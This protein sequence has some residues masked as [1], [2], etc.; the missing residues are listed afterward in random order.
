MVAAEDMK[1]SPRMLNGNS[2]EI[3][4]VARSSAHGLCAAARQAKTAVANTTE[5][6][7][8]AHRR[9]N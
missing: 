9:S 5:W 6:G 7:T 8:D 3:S 2:V 4:H 1:H